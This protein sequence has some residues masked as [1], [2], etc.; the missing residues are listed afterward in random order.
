MLGDHWVQHIVDLISVALPLE[1]SKKH[2]LEDVRGDKAP[3]VINHLVQLR[4]QVIQYAVVQV[5]LVNALDDLNHVFA[6]LI[7]LSRV[8]CHLLVRHVKDT[9]QVGAHYFGS[10]HIR[11]IT[12]H[13]RRLGR[14]NNLAGH[15][16]RAPRGLRNAGH[17]YTS[18][19]LRICILI[20]LRSF[21]AIR[22]GDY[23][24]GRAVERVLRVL[25]FG[26][27]NTE[28]FFIVEG[29]ERCFV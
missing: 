14:F 16:V 10:H 17:R 28:G 5:Q 8:L 12:H 4:A 13:F 2:A 25:L 29:L 22:V 26:L 15:R 24:V 23:V 6:F 3:L 9:L 21:S 20:V 1:E 7:L 11:P 19:W 18:E 27:L